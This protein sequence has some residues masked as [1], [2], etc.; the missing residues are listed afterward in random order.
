MGLS[1]A[2]AQA[3]ASQQK[4]PDATKDAPK[5]V[6]QPKAPEPAAGQTKTAQEQFK[7]I[8]VLKT[9]PAEDLLP[10]MRYISAALGVECN[11]CHV[12]NPDFAPEKDDKKEK[13]TAR[14][15]MQM[16]MTINQENFEGHQDVSCNSCHNGHS[17]PQTIPPMATE[18]AIKERLQARANQPPQGAPGQPQ[19]QQPQQGPPR[20]ARPSAES[21]FQKY[22]QAIG[23]SAAIGKITSRYL[24]GT[25]SSAFGNSEYEQYNKTPDK[26]WV[27]TSTPRGARV[28]AWDGSQGWTKTDRVEPVRDTF[29]AKYNSDF[30]RNLKFVDRYKGARVFRKEKVGDRDAWVVMVRIPDSPLSDMLYFDTDSGLLLRRTTLR[31]TALGPLPSTA[32]F[33]DYRNVGG[34]KM[35]FKVTLS[36]PDSLQNI[37]VSEIKIN[38]PVEDTRFAMPASTE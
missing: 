37:Q 32:D 35:P 7:N 9:V 17:R 13:Q 2:M 15:M 27:L 25:V 18:A 26:F 5:A 36:T 29:D 19:A 21:L 28:Q 33:D 3:P 8:Q 10:T 23:G 38:V 14:K 11:F 16:V 4:P 30:Y 31:R 34:V 12:R 22:E 20:E 1:S 24:K 6:E